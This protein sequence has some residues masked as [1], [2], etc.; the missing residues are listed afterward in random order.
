MKNNKKVSNN[1]K[2][3]KKRSN[4]KEYV[5]ISICIIIVTT[6][7]LLMAVSNFIANE[8]LI[9]IQLLMISLFGYFIT[10]KLIKERDIKKYKKVILSFFILFMLANMYY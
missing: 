2:S 8:S 7:T 6:L 3:N 4:E 10:F 9:G 1:K 5:I